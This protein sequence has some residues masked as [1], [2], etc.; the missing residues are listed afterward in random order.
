MLRG[1]DVNEIVD[2]IHIA[3]T[4]LD[5]AGEPVP[6]SLCR[7]HLPSCQVHMLRLVT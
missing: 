4:L 7:L 6:D 5:A 2:A 1:R 3:P